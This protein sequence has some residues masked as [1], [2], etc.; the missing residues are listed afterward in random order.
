MK[1]GIITAIPQEFKSVMAGLGAITA[2]QHGTIREGRCRSAGHEVLLVESGMG[3][4]N[5]AG[6]AGMLI[7]ENNPDLLITTGFCGGIAAELHAGDIVVA[8]QIVIATAGGFEDV[9][10]CFSGSGQTFVVRQAA[11]GTRVVAGVFISTATLVSKKQL[12]GLI[13]GH[14]PN[15]VVEMESAAIAIVAAEHGVPLLGIRAVSDTADEELGF[16]L[17]E[18]C[19]TDMR[20][21]RPDKVLQT[22][23]R[24]PHIIP[25][26]IR[27]NRS[28]RCAAQ[29]LTAAFSRLLPTL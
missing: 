12:A 17:E 24:K 6:A 15:P 2:T 29:S 8:K 27:L 11:E 14:F 21:I 22:V 19:D 20:R 9:P 25:Q 1:I 28:S 4:D 10:V 26:L 7:R 5:A 16:S 18:F 3:F 23:L 13:F